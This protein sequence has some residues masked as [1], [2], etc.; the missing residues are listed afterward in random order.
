[1]KLYDNEVYIMSALKSAK[2][3][4]QTS[5]S[6]VKT[7]TQSKNWAAYLGMISFALLA[8]GCPPKDD[9]TA[10]NVGRGDARGPTLSASGL[11]LVGIVSGDGQ[12]PDDF[13]SSV[14][15]LMNAS[16]PEEAVCPVDLSSGVRIGGQVQTQGSISQAVNSGARINI[17]PTS[18]MDI[19]VTDSCSGRPD[20]SGQVVPALPVI[21]LRTATGFVQGNYAAIR[22]S[23]SHGWV[24][25]EGTLD[26]TEFR[27]TVSY[28]NYRIYSGNGPG[29]A[30]TL[31]QFRI[32]TCQFFQCN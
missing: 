4:S 11:S 18:R 7:V 26:R 14:K 31:G 28:D 23:D 17:N 1:M 13:T 22:F 19:Q 24:T 27:G 30:G 16:L 9:G 15:G 29:G 2:V 10:I 3:N 21:S 20:A 12:T 32:A 6:L 8:S 25:L 5:R